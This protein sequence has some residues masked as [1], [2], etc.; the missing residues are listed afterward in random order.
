MSVQVWLNYTTVHRK[1]LKC[2]YTILNW[3]AIL[4][5]NRIFDIATA[6]ARDAREFIR[7]IQ[8]RKPYRPEP[9]AGAAGKT[10]SIVRQ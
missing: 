2:R 9:S 10:T 1:L 6:V 8:R 4:L 5:E 3:L 7:Y